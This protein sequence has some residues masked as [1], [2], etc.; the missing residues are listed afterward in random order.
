MA[1]TNWTIR[2]TKYFFGPEFSKRQVRLLIT[3][4]VLDEA[5]VDLGG[6]VGFLRA[7]QVGPAWLRPDPGTLH[8]RAMSLHNVWRSP[9]SW[10]PSGYP[11]KLIALRDVPPYLPYLCLLCLAWTEGED[12]VTAGNAF[13][14]RLAPLYSNNGLDALHLGHWKEL[15]DDLE[16]WSEKLDRKWGYFLVE[17]LGNRANV[18]IPRSQVILTP[19]KVER[20]P[21][22]FWRCH[23]PAGVAS[24]DPETLR[25]ALRAKETES[26]QVL[27]YSLFDEISANTDLGKSACKMITEYLEDWDGQ[28]PIGFESSAGQDVANH[29]G[30][31]E[32]RLVLTPDA[33]AEL[34]HVAFGMVEQDE[35]IS[36]KV[37]SK[38]WQL[39]NYDTNLDILE[40]SLGKPVDAGYFASRWTT[41]LQL[42]AQ[43]CEDV[44]GDREL[45]LRLPP[46]K[47]RIFSWMGSRL[48]E[49]MD[50]P[51]MGSAFLLL[52]PSIQK[53]WTQWIN[54]A[55]SPLSIRD[56]T[57]TGLPA[58]FKLLYADN[59]HALNDKA[60]QE[61]PSE[62]VGPRNRV[63]LVR[64]IG[65]SRANRV[66][67]RR[68]YA[69]YDPP[70]LAVEASAE[71][72]LKVH[73]ATET[74]V[75]GTATPANLP[76][77]KTRIYSLL[78]PPDSSLVVARAYLDGSE[79]GHAS[80]GVWQDT[81]G[82]ESSTETQHFYLDQFAQPVNGEGA[83]GIS[84][85]GPKPK[86][87][88]LP[89]PHIQGA[90]IA[91]GLLEAPSFLFLE[92]LALG[93]SRFPYQEYKRRA[94]EITNL[95]FALLTRETR[96]LIDLAHVEL[97]SDTR[98]RWAYIH[99][100]PLA[101]YP[102]PYKSKDRFQAVL[103]GCA[104]RT[105]I[106]KVLN[107]ATELGCSAE[108]VSTASKL[109]P[110]RIT[111]LHAD[112]DAFGLISDE[113]KLTWTTT[114]PALQFATW[115]GSLATWLE[116]LHKKGAFFEG[117]GPSPM[118]EYWPERFAIVDGSGHH[119]APYR[120]CCMEDTQTQRH[121]WHTLVHHNSQH[122]FVR[123]P[124]L[125]KW[126][127]QRA[128][129]DSDWRV[130]F[131]F[132]YEN[133]QT[134]VPYHSGTA[135]LVIPRGLGLP[136]LLSR[137]ASLCSG[138][139]PQLVSQCLAFSSAQYGFLPNEDADSYFGQCWVYPCV[140]PEI[141]KTLLCKLSAEPLATANASVSTFPIHTL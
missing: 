1:F 55:G 105:R 103:C 42:Q 68:L 73:G 13:Y 34:W 138:L 61:F 123:D 43:A 33:D 113:L 127:V 116:S 124:S 94:N 2:L 25:Q 50:L 134:F 129:T 35:A 122:T 137:A 27:G 126:E 47:L 93:N 38:S 9:P 8:G 54:S 76:G 14:G 77:N 41:G 131:G 24:F 119:H 49:L 58:G 57:R 4:S 31:Y 80:F 15:W 70:K 117:F 72:E 19:R 130:P 75:G 71:L 44:T 22:L 79:V 66:T 114:P 26:R 86:W 52:E 118:R 20:L 81:G 46:A 29:R 39:A 110:P 63:R 101:L 40:Q 109:V 69:R 36:I 128:A 21:E 121:W 100:L 56:F 23:L 91:N 85:P 5:F 59:L 48:V 60:R 84:A 78:I 67:S 82:E 62:N 95:E 97:E 140:P 17:R 6:T 45:T 88:Y 111:F 51:T 139:P 106:Q 65:G 53:D 141:A 99:P 12:Q 104:S 115:S 28:P 133:E 7:L 16:K 89:G 125:A 136:Y 120:L 83:F 11:A 92:S 18:D 30:R 112:L 74:L 87:P 32:L 102:L 135:S 64:F 107:L 108:H 90:S 3:R 96:W 37:P 98:G 132:S 10:R